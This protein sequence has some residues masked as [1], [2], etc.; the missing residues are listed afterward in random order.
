VL[1]KK[2]NMTSQDTY[3]ARLDERL[4]SIEHK[5]DNSIAS[6]ERK[7]QEYDNKEDRIAERVT[8]LEQRIGIFAALGTALVFV[9]QIVGIYITQAFIK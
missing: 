9:A 3:L 6:Q 8:I 5:L 4:K 2:N 1:H 7:Q